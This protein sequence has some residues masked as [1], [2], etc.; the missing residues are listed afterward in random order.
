VAAY[1]YN[2]SYVGS[3]G[4]IV[5]QADPEQKARNPLQKIAKTKKTKGM[6]EV[7]EHL[8]RKHE[9]LSIFVSTL[10]LPKNFFSDAFY[11]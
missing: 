8:P 3:I 9:V 11:V 10:V 6:V 4:R 1:A 2:P 7:V 5:V